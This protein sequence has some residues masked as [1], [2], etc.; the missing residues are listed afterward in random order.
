MFQIERQEKIL[1]YINKKKKANVNELSD[2]FEVSKVTIRRDLDE[3]SE[4]GLVVKTHGGVM[5][6]LNKFSYEIPSSSKQE[7][8]LEAKRRIGA[9]AAKLIEDGDIVIFDAGSTTLEVAKNIKNQEITVLTNDIKISMEMAHKRSIKLM[10]SGGI[11]NES[12]YTL[13]GDQTVEFFEKVHVNK[14]FLGC[15]AIDLSFGISNRTMEEVETKRA[16][17]EAAEEVIMVTD[18]SKL[19][20]KV[21][22]HLC[23]ISE[24]DKLIINEIDDVYKRELEKKGVEVIIAP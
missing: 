19:N 2:I 24:I 21:F 4:K 1:Q 9:E 10:V 23:E 6:I 3:L 16:M 11:L 12:V 15:D 20:K 8:N 22:C 5:S 13:V 7:S 17:I 14:T 18:S